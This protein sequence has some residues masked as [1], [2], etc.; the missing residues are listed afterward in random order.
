MKTKLDTAAATVASV[1]VHDD[2]QDQC[3]IEMRRGQVLVIQ[4][5]IITVVSILVYCAVCFQSGID[6]ELAAI[7]F[8]GASPML[9]ATLVGMGLSTMLWL[10][11][12][13]MYLRAAMEADP[14]KVPE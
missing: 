14:A 5:M 4:G 11:G 13:V 1:V 9:L 2:A 6:T 8:D 3:E 10:F 12:C 7:L